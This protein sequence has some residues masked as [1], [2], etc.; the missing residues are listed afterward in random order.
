ML[1]DVGGHNLTVLAAGVSQNVLDEIVSVLIARDIDERDARTVMTT[2]ADAVEVTAQEFGAANFEA[3]LNYLGSEL[4]CAVFCGVANH[5]VD[6]TAAVGRG[7][8]LANVL[9]A[10]VAKLAMGDD[11]DVGEDF[12]NAWA[13]S[14]LVCVA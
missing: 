9:D 3:L 7:A 6:G 13:L 10:P 8:V 11:V 12:L 5:M 4:I 14:S 2:L 1:P